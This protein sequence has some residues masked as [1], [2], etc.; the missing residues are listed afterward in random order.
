MIQNLIKKALAP[1]IETLL[2]E[3]RERINHIIDGMDNALD[4]MNRI[5][6]SDIADAIANSIDTYDLASRIASDIN[7]DIDLSGIAE[8]IDTSGI[9]D[10][11]V[12]QLET[13]LEIQYQNTN[14]RLNDIEVK[15]DAILKHI[16]GVYVGR[17]LD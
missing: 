5:H 13:T 10:A 7:D 9:A 6:S 2:L 17:T 3:E 1:T 16:G 11:V 14:N 12:S 8:D 4:E 15:M